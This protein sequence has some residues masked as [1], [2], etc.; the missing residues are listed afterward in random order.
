MQNRSEKQDHD[1]DKEKALKKDLGLWD[2]YSIATGAMF[3]SG[4]FLLPG[5]A[6]AQ[7]G[8]STVLAYL[9]AGVF[10]LPSMLSMLE[11]AT[12][13]PRAG[14]AYYFLDRSLGPAVGTIAGIGSWLTLVFK[15]AFALVG[16][17]AYL[18]ISP[19]IGSLVDSTSSGGI[20]LIKALAV[21]M[22][23]VF[24]LVNILGAKESTRVQSFLVVTLLIVLGLFLVQGLWHVFTVLPF[25]EVAGQFM[26][27]LHQE[28]GVSGFFATIGLVFVSFGG[29]T[30]VASISEE[31]DRPERNLPLGMFLSLGTAMIVYVLGVFIM[32]AVL[33]AQALRQ[34][35]APVATAAKGFLSW[36]PGNMGVILVILSALAAFTSTGN[37][38]ILSASRYPLAMARDRLVPERF[39]KLGR[40]RTPSA[41]IL[42][43]GATIVLFILVFSARDVAKLGSTFNLM[44]L[45]LVNVAVL[46]M[47]ESEIVTYDPGFS[48]PFYPWIPL[49][50]IFVNSWLIVEMGAT[51]IAFSV[52][53]TILGAIWYFRY[54][55]PRVDRYG[56]VHHV[57]ARLGRY[58]HAELLP[59]FREIMKEK[60][61]RDEDPYD[62][63]VERTAFFEVEDGQSMDGLIQEGV[64]KLAERVDM[65]AE[66][67]KE[68]LQRTGRYGGAPMSLGVVLLHLQAPEVEQAEMVLA[69]ARR[70]ICVALPSDDP[71]Q[72]EETSCDVFAVV[73]LVSPE[74]KV[75]QHL[76][77]LAQLADRAEDP[78]F[79]RAWQRVE[80]E[81]K[82]KE[83]LLRDARFLE[84]FVSRDDATRSLIGAR[85]DEIDL[86]PEAFIASVRRGKD[87]F[88]PSGET[89]M[90]ASDALTIIGSP[91]AIDRV[92]E[93]Y[94]E[95]KSEGSGSVE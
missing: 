57:F 35:L 46:V 33:D 49:V 27:F 72:G 18:A 2:V 55:R 12:A 86:P 42:I 68:G 23:V 34:D 95:G 26:P 36:L 41:G 73:F 11:L 77:V 62:D 28:N 87:H 29:L 61:L 50:G 6:T 21:A 45:A 53:V 4:F 3:S 48:V 9:V 70:G 8:P 88:E 17:G 7:A 1:P 19:G 31:V 20:W 78:A 71:T 85:I 39:E 80:G 44:V 93:R 54:A 43:T 52:G 37:A 40:F 81:A 15:S 64:G 66:A 94:V 67:I 92:Y 76:R 84:V 25:E 60:G 69:R 91:D 38:G 59:E 56:A 22:T 75:G 14:G 30:K 63:I 58:R 89:E 51:S 47:R 24:V 83:L 82:L 13:L 79:R 10:I 16:M 5:I 74:S 32:I 90:E 65:D